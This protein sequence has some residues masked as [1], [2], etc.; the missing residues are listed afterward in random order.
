VIPLGEVGED[1]GEIGGDEVGVEVNEL[2]VVIVG[3]DEEAT[4][5][6]V[7]IDSKQTVACRVS[8]KAL[9]SPLTAIS[10]NDPK[11]IDGHRLI[12]LSQE[13]DQITPPTCNKHAIASVCSGTHS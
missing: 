11:P 2:D 8:P 6:K 13:P 5:E 10:I 3:L 12:F 7:Y 4:T 9:K 1:E